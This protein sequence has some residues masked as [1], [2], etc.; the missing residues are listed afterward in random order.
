MY[1]RGP[2]GGA[3]ASPHCQSPKQRPWFRYSVLSL[4]EAAILNYFVSIKK[5][6]QILSRNFKKNSL[7]TIFLIKEVSNYF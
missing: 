6:T 3:T 1:T 4:I 2:E 5:S 7:Y